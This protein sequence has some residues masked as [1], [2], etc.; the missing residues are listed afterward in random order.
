MEKEKQFDGKPEFFLASSLC[1]DNNMLLW[2]C[3]HRAEAPLPPPSAYEC[4]HCPRC[5]RRVRGRRCGRVYVCVLWLRRPETPSRA[6]VQLMEEA[7]IR[8]TN[9]HPWSRHCTHC[10]YYCRSSDN[11]TAAALSTMG[12]DGRHPKLHHCSE[13]MSVDLKNHLILKLHFTD[14]II[15]VCNELLPPS[16][17]LNWGNV[18]SFLVMSWDVFWWRMLWR[19]PAAAGGSY[20][21]REEDTLEQGKLGIL[22]PISAP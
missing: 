3:L 22:S 7:L 8:T 12:I 17:H 1:L 2:W 6:R 5:P 16:K 10:G 19:A 20:F 4:P 18:C 14:H 11:T 15:C 9:I 13:V 21:G